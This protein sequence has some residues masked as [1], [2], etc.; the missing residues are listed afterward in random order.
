MPLLGKKLEHDLVPPPPG[1]DP[2][3]Q[4][5]VI[6][7]THEIFRDYE[8]VP[9][10]PPP[11]WLGRTTAIACPHSVKL[12]LFTAQPLTSA[13]HST[14][15]KPNRLSLTRDRPKF[16]GEAAWEDSYRTGQPTFVPTATPRCPPHPASEPTRGVWVW[17]RGSEYLKA[18]H[19]YRKRQWMCR[20][21][22]KEGCTYEEALVRR[23][24]DPMHSLIRV[25][26]S[27]SLFFAHWVC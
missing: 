12:D 18:L 19:F 15:S 25:A 27:N 1:L 21:T 7:F 14:A 6:R 10:A 13:Y 17:V 8:C 4:V 26:R 9:R 23:V 22:G 5:F 3:E 16:S 2:N 20:Y 11:V 24:H